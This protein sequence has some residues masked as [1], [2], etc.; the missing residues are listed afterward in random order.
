[1]TR[2][3]MIRHGE[4]EANQSGLFA[5]HLDVDLTPRGRIQAERTAQYIAE[6]FAVDKVYASDLKRAFRTGEAVAKRL[7][8]EIIPRQDLREI[9]AGEW[10]GA[11]FDSLAQD[12]P[13]DFGTWLHDLP[14]ARCTGGESVAELANRIFSA[15]TEIA[16]EN[17]GKTV[18]IATHATPVRAMMAMI[19]PNGL[20]EMER[21][22]WVPNA[23][24]TVF[25]YDNGNWTCEL[26][27][28]AAHLADL[29]TVL[30]ANV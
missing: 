24:V 19:H 26:V 21:I 13:E 3:I 2:L 23:S 29:K 4:S 30:P 15:L 20:A 6:H 9:A 16:I 10:E 22:G 7:G 12:Y 28:E 18:A 11:V 25:V 1:M 14:H 27:G 5:G 17:A 8:I